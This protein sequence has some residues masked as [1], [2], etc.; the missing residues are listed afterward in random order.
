MTNL[1]WI[2]KASIVFLLWAIAAVALPAQTFTTLYNFDGADGQYPYAPLVQGIDGN[3]Y[4]ATASGGP[5]EDGEIFKMT[6]SGALTTIYY[7]GGT[8]AALVL[9]TDGDFYGT[10]VNGGSSRAC[11]SNGCGTVFKITP[12][13]TFATLYGFD[14]TDGYAPNGLVQGADG[15]FYGTTFIGGAHHAGTVFKITPGGTLT[16]LHTFDVTDGGFPEGALV[17]ATDGNF[18]GTTYYGGSNSE[19][20]SKYGCGT[21]FKITPSGTLTTL[22]SFDETDGDGPGAGLVQASDGDLYGTTGGGGAYYDG[23]VFK[24]TLGGSFTMLHTFDGTDGADPDAALIQ[25]TDGNLYGVTYSGGTNTGG[26][27]EVTCGTIFKITLS[28]TLTTLHDFNYTDG[29]DPHALVQATD[30]T[31]YGSTLYGGTYVTAGTIFSLSVGLKPFVETQPSS[32]AVGAAVNILG[33]DL[34]GATSVTFNGT[35]A[36]FTVVSKTLI[37]TT[38]PA[39]AITGTVEVVRPNGKGLS[40]VPFRV[41]P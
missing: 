10:T 35:P 18:Y 34:T 13:G 31:F 39:G 16:T 40:N 17:Q 14:L 23:T 38:V 12:S 29:Y 5:S 19:C 33:S 37:T 4:G 15:D 1:D 11:G 7:G 22:H 30:G 9:V 20:L 41:L 25:A 2:T 28:G 32:G 8:D 21:V 6:P 27:N 26:C 3:L 24:I 36:V